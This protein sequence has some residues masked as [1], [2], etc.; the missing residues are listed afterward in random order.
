MAGAYKKPSDKKRGPAGKYTI[1]WY[2]EDGKR[3]FAGRHAQNPV[4]TFQ[5]RRQRVDA[6]EAA[7]PADRFP[8]R[9]RLRNL[10]QA[11]VELIGLK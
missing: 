6:S 8:I 7:Q 1:W 11:R 10:G 5:D 2:G 4:F 3:R 9:I